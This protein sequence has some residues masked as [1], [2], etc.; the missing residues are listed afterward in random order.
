MG[1]VDDPQPASLG[2]LVHC[3]LVQ[4]MADPDFAGRDRYRHAL[5]NKAPGHR[6]AVRV[7]F[8]GAIIADDAGQFT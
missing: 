4:S 8:D 6:V 3:Y 1:G 5:A 2:L 7:D